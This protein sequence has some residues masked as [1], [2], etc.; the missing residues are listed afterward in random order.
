MARKTRETAGQTTLN[1]NLNGNSK[2]SGTNFVKL[3]NIGGHE[4]EKLI[5]DAL[6]KL[7]FQNV[8]VVSKGPDGGVDI[9]AEQKTKLG[10]IV[11]FYIE[12]KH[13][14]DASIGRPV[15]QKLDS[16]V[17]SGKADKG[18][19][20]T[21]GTFSAQ[22]IGYAEKVGIDLVDGDAIKKILKN[23]GVDFDHHVAPSQTTPIS[24]RSAVES[25]VNEY[26]KKRETENL[27]SISIEKIAIKL[28]PTYFCHFKINSIFSTSVG[29]IYTINEESYILVDAYGNQLDNSMLEALH[30]F[31]N[32]SE[33]VQPQTIRDIEVTTPEKRIPARELMDFMKKNIQKTYATDVSYYG[34]NNRS[35]TK[36]CVPSITDIDI[37]EATEAMVPE[38]LLSFSLNESK[39]SLRALDFF[40]TFSIIEDTS[41]TCQICKQALKRAVLCD[42]C[43]KIVCLRHTCKCK[44]CGKSL[45]TNCRKEKK[46]WLILSD[47]FCK[48]CYGTVAKSEKEKNSGEG[49]FDSL[50]ARLLKTKPISTLSSFTF[51]VSLI[52]IVVNFFVTL[53]A[54]Y[55]VGVAVGVLDGLKDKPALCLVY[56]LLGLLLIALTFLCV[57]YIFWFPFYFVY[58]LIKK[59]FGGKR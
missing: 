17:R 47:S 39:H 21:S 33:N 9:S 8:H 26:L 30:S 20:I 56:F 14:P 2:N 59:I 48:S 42:E 57:F 49:S 19:I 31:L 28:R 44:N 25:F 43:S 41:S 7:D 40:G 55:F 37:I 58:R 6:T 16:A 18:M 32:N 52:G 45:C 38:W 51:P 4:F 13:W 24:D 3:G 15:V 54:I 12:C 11:K 29:V 50:V 36:M 35:Y 27:K 22:A 53:I 23:A 10:T 5:A 1:E 46:S 34:S